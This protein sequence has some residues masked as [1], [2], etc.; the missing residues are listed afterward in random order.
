MNT[1]MTNNLSHYEYTVS[2]AILLIALS[3]TSITLI[4]TK[5]FLT[6]SILI[7]LVITLVNFFT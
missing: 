6:E 2:E 7:P 4:Y 1:S 3:G 5:Y